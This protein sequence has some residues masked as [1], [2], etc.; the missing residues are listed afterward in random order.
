MIRIE[1][2]IKLV[3]PNKLKNIIQNFTFQIN[4]PTFQIKKL[5]KI[6]IKLRK[7]K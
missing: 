5:L 7:E 2:Y 1:S 3:H 6:S 4:I